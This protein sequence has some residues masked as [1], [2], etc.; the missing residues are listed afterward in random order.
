MAYRP[1]PGIR[2]YRNYGLRQ[3]QFTPY[4][5]AIAAPVEEKVSA[6]HAGVGRA[7]PRRRLRV[8]VVCGALL[9]G[10]Y[11]ALLLLMQSATLAEN[12]TL[13]PDRFPLVFNWLRG[14]FPP[15]WLAADRFSPL[16]Q[17]NVR[18]YLLI[19]AWLFLVY[20]VA[21]RL[22]FRPGVF[23]AAHGSSALR[24]ILL[25]TAAMLFVLLFVAGNFS[26][27]V[28]SY[29]WYGRIPA[30][31]GGNPYINTPV[32][33][34]GADTTGWLHYVFFTDL[35]SVYG[36]VWQ[37]LAGGIAKLAHAVAG[38]DIFYHLLGHR[39]LADISHLVTVALLW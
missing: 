1:E 21:L 31:E 11:V 34:A 29:I 20:I 10:G 16:G 4:E 37:L 5:P 28:F 38:L 23:V 15:D 12:P 2:A 32:Q 17:L 7:T 9:L 39:L 19:I 22:L 30:L 36:P 33:Y 18:L 6:E 25:F 14:L 24:W 13:I 3:A 8:L 35:V 26:D 27:D